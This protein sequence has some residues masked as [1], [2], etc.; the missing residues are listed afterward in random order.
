MVKNL[1]IRNF[2]FFFLNIIVTIER[3]APTSSN[4]KIIMIFHS[5]FRMEKK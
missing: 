4:R 2:D 1:R 3:Y 5:R